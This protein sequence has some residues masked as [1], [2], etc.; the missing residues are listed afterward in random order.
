ME[1]TLRTNLTWRLGTGAWQCFERA[2][3]K[4]SRGPGETWTAPKHACA[5]T[6][7]HLM[8]ALKFHF[9]FGLSVP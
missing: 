3:L 4:E 1:A 8:V 2:G 7:L 5:A 6:P 9:V